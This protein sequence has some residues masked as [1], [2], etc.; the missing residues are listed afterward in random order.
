MKDNFYQ[1][2]GVI[3]RVLDKAVFEELYYSEP[4]VCKLILDQ[5][6][7]Y[8]SDPDFDKL[9]RQLI[10]VK[11]LKNNYPLELTRDVIEYSNNSRYAD[12]YVRVIMEW[13]YASIDFIKQY[14]LS[15]YDAS[16]LAFDADT[17]AEYDLRKKKLVTE[18][19]IVSDIT[20]SLIGN[21]DV[22]E[23]G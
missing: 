19:D 9:E 6:K 21:K 11:F 22:G 18:I 13:N 3:E 20:N 7:T 1:K 8:L 14:C 5:F 12:D 4:F 10:L 16:L 17:K 23:D 15:Q 2:I